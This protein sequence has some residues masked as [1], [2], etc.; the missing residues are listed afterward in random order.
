MPRLAKRYQV[1]TIVGMTPWVSMKHLNTMVTESL[2]PLEL[3]T[4]RPNMTLRGPI[5]IQDASISNIYSNGDISTTNVIQLFISDCKVG[6]SIGDAF[7][8][9]GPF[10]SI[11]WPLVEMKVLFGSV[12]LM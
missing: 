7:L 10:D 12:T 5:L 8:P 3:Q 6:R 9:A 4:T 2:S 11:S 1:I